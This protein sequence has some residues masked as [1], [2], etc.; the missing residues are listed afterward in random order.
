MSTDSG[1]QGPL[2]TWRLRRRGPDQDPDQA[3]EARPIS[4]R[5]A[6][7]E[8]GRIDHPLEARILTVGGT[9]EADLARIR[10]ICG[11]L[12]ADAEMTFLVLASHRRDR[13]PLDIMLSEGSDLSDYVRHRLA[14]W[15]AILGTDEGPP[16]DRSPE[17]GSSRVE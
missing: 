17:L 15:E 1:L 4:P 11:E 12:G 3:R 5:P 7:R 13:A 6:S 8:P 14:I 16:P 9:P 10:E 2:R